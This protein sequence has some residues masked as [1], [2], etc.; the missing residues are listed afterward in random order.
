MMVSNLVDTM[1]TQALKYPTAT[2]AIGAGIVAATVLVAASGASLVALPLGLLATAIAA[3][4][5][6][7]KAVFFPKL[8][9]EYGLKEDDGGQL[10][11]AK[12]ITRGGSRLNKAGLSVQK[13]ATLLGAVVVHIR[14]SVR[15]AAG[16]LSFA[17]WRKELRKAQSRD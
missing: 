8:M 14:A 16:V 1:K 12:E 6:K 4:V 5:L 10:E 3:F 7:N 9:R 17:K 13:G 2:L 11:N 15:A